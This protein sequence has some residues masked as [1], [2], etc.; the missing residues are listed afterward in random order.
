MITVSKSAIDQIKFQKQY[1][2]TIKTIRVFM[3]SG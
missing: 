2:P 1:L 3:S